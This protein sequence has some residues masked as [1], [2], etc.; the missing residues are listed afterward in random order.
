MIEL[1]KW[2]KELHHKVRLNVGFHSDLSWWKCFLPIWNGSCSMASAI[3]REPQTTDASG[4]WECGA[5]TSTGDWFQLALSGDWSD[6]HIT[7]SLL[8]WVWLC[9]APDGK[10]GRCYAAVTMLPSWPL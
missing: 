9:G 1:S 6:V 7:A 4:N 5:Y 10:V 3:P 2:V 8:Y